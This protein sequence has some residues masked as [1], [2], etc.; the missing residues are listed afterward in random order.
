MPVSL[1]HGCFEDQLENIKPL[2]LQEI[3]QLLQATPGWLRQLTVA[4]PRYAV[5][6]HP[7]PGTWCIKQVIGH[8][9][10]EDQR[11]FV[12]RMQLM[13]EEPGATLFITDQDEVARKRHDCDKRLHD[14]LAEFD[15]VRTSSI[16]FVKNVK[17][18]DLDRTGVH[19][20]IGRIRI[21]E[22][23]HEWIY[24]DFNH[25][26]QISGNVQHVLRDHLGNM[27]RFYAT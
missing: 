2:D 6:H 18:T 17:L 9:I 19:S 23:L 14:L 25:V 1:R 15:F 13:L 3:E 21:G 7:R 10:E 20:K 26:K 5:A 16:A 8:L 22:L 4:L 12:G 24:H 27:Q 11:D